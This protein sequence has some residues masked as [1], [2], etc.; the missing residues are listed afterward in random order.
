MFL[1]R[2]TEH[3]KHIKGLLNTL[4]HAVYLQHDYLCSVK[5]VILIYY[6]NKQETGKW[7]GSLYYINR[8]YTEDGSRKFV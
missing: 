3:A 2:N 7:K 1:R 8:A 4:W 6:I 5:H